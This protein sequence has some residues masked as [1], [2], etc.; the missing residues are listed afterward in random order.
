MPQLSQGEFYWY[1]LEGLKVLSARGS[2]QV[3]LGEVSH[4]L[5]TGAN[6]VL[7]VQPCAGSID[8]RERMLPWVDDNVILGV[9]LAAGEIRVDWD[10]TF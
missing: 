6:D 3:L 9:D 1:Q 10:P 7:V 5:E 2:Q 4:L 8:D